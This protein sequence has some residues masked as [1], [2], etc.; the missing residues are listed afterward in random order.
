MVRCSRVAKQQP[1]THNSGCRRRV[2][3]QS[4][5][6]YPT[7]PRHVRLACHTITTLHEGR[8]SIFRHQEHENTV[9]SAP[10]VKDTPESTI[11]Y[12]TFYSD[13]EH[14]VLKVKSGDLPE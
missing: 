3:P 9:D 5:Q 10:S 11:A 2:L 7:W 13:V 14:V 8:G 4:T 12:V 1:L 6:R